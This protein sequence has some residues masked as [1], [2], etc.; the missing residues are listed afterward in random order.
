M[1]RIL[2]ECTGVVPCVERSGAGRKL[3]FLQRLTT[4]A[5][6][7]TK[8]RV[9]GPDRVSGS[10]VF[11]SIAE[12]PSKVRL[13]IILVGLQHCEGAKEVCCRSIQQKRFEPT[14]SME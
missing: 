13:A 5:Q 4:F 9:Q 11:L 12:L 8:V 7:E 10:K 1:Y 2:Q 14:A 6:M 3:L